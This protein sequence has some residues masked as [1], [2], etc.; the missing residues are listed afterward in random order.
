MTAK[1]AARGAD[2][3]KR[4]TFPS[5]KGELVRLWNEFCAIAPDV[6][7][8]GVPALQIQ[9]PWYGCEIGDENEDRSIRRISEKRQSGADAAKFQVT[10]SSA[11]AWRLKTTFF[12]RPRVTSINDPIRVRPRRKGECKPRAIGA[13]RRPSSSGERPLDPGLRSF[14]NGR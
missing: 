10:H 2:A 12:Y 9:Q 3:W 7:G 6:S 5:R 11:K 1:P 8:K 4:P 13:S 14:P